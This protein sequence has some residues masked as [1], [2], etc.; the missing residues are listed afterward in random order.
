MSFSKYVSSASSPDAALKNNQGHR[1]C[2]HPH[3]C[4]G[5]GWSSDVGLDFCVI[6]SWY[7]HLVCYFQT[8][9][10]KRWKVPR[11]TS[12]FL[13]NRFYEYMKIWGWVPLWSKL[14][15]AWSK[16]ESRSGFQE[17]LK[18]YSQSGF[19]WPTTLITFVFSLTVTVLDRLGNAILAIAIFH[20]A[21]YSLRAV[22]SIASPFEGFSRF[23]LEV[24]TKILQ[25]SHSEAEWQNTSIQNRPPDTIEEAY[26][27]MM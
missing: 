10:L 19:S 6:S 11:G 3:Q 27:V 1:L 14:R 26:K 9:N 5:V 20:L 18:Q 21:T 15:L 8:R 4:T 17:K 13:P 2:I 7:R 24:F 16:F 23:D 25:W 12:V 22:S